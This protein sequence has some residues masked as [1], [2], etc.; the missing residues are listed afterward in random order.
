LIGNT[1]SSKNLLASA[2]TTAFSLLSRFRRLI[3]Q[4]LDLYEPEMLDA[5]IARLSRVVAI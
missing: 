1:R 5:L 2:E 3:R 4:H